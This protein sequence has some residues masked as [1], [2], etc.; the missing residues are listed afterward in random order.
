MQRAF[1]DNAAFER[2]AATGQLL[3]QPGNTLVSL[4]IALPG[5]V[6]LAWLNNSVTNG[7]D[8]IYKDLSLT[9]Q[10]LLKRYLRDYYF[11]DISRYQDLASAYL[12]LLYAAIPPENSIIIGGTTSTVDDD[13]YWD[14]TNIDAVNGMA[15]LARDS[16]SSQGFSAQLAQAQSRLLAAG[17]PGL[18]KFFDPKGVIGDFNLA[19]ADTGMGRLKD[20][21]LFVESNVITDA[22]EAALDAATFN[23][24]AAAN[25]PVE[26]LKA[27]ADFGNTIVE[28]FNHDL[29][30]VFVQDNDALQRVS[31][32]IFA[33]AS[34]VFDPS[35]PSTNYDSTLNV[36]VLKPGVAMPSDFPDFTIAPDDISVSLN[37]AS[38]G[39]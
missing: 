30:S 22:H 12:V 18:A 16:T 20:T 37:A 2:W 38:F 8:Q 1:P 39:V 24:L 17:Q 27:L 13:I 10:F 33:Q 19:I 7:K 6:P 15:R 11:R 25:K 5:S 26:A 3:R 4:D 23:A 35:I 36:T 21:L 31:P 34:S 9:L 28:A 14:V 29:S 32:L